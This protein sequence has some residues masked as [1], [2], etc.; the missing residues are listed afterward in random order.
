ME[1]NNLLKKHSEIQI[2]WMKIRNPQNEEFQNENLQN[3]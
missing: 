2:I 3:K 1:S